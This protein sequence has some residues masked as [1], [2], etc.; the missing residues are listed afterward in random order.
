MS[1]FI[2]HLLKLPLLLGTGALI[3]LLLFWLMQ[4]LIHTEFSTT[5]PQPGTRIADITEPD[6]D[7]I[8][9]KRQPLPPKPLERIEPPPLAPQSTSVE[10]RNGT[11]FV[12]EK[13]DMTHD[14]IAPGL[15]IAHA[16]AVPLVQVA[17][18]YPQRSQQRG[19]EGYV[20]VQ[21]DVD[22][23][24]LV[25][26]AHVLYA[27]PEGYFENAAL[28]AL[29]RYRYQPRM[30]NGEALAMRGLQQKLSFTLED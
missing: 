15:A 28:R 14:P 21:F 29:E 11:G 1:S 4:Q 30:V 5:A 12:F 7:I 9:N 2:Q 6:F 20:V 18:A 17:P 22:P 3:T 27:E 26:N 23:Q 19:V 10:P 24:G 8:V 25:V 13:P 16:N